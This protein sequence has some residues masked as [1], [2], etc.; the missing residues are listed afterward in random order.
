M[1]DYFRHWTRRLIYTSAVKFH[2]DE[3][4]AFWLIDAI[5]SHLP[6]PMLRRE[7]FMVWKLDVHPDRSARLWVTDGNSDTPIVQQAI[8]FTDYPESHAEFYVVRTPGEP[9]VLMLPC[10]Y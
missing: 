6:N 8:E 5:A 2:A 1:N 4:G 10:D 3:A 7:E 9:D